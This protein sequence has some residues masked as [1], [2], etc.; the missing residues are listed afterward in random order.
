MNATT[1]LHQG[2]VMSRRV[3][4]AL[5]L[6]AGLV[7]GQDAT[8]Q[9]ALAPTPLKPDQPVL[10]EAG[11]TRHYRIDAARH[12]YGSYPLQIWRGKL[13]PLLYAIAVI[14]TSVDAQGNIVALQA[15]REPAHAKEVTAWILALI[16]G[17]QPFPT[18]QR[19]GEATWTEVWLVDE[20]GHFQL[21]ALS[22]GQR[23]D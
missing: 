3:V 5:L 23:D 13:P 6:A 1:P 2:H 17:A 8:A 14:Q 18:P 16:R 10:S 12:V 19:L 22:E 21:D 11:D 20:S 15:T 9:F 4:L 7:H